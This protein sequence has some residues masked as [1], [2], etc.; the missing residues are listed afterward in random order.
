MCLTAQIVLRPG[1]CHRG[2]S[3]FDSVP[4][5]PTRFTR[6]HFLAFEGPST[7]HERAFLRV[8]PQDTLLEV[9]CSAACV[10]VSSVLMMHLL[11]IC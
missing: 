10:S 1:S 4:F 9:R 2:L 11:P 3:W 6:W 8:W 7:G 5:L